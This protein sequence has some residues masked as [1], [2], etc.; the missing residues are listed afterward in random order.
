MAG[1]DA[2]HETCLFGFQSG[3]Y[4]IKSETSLLST[5]TW[6]LLEGD[7]ATCNELIWGVRLSRHKDCRFD[8]D[9]LRTS[10]HRRER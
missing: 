5:I 6:K 7:P 4:E 3:S 2:N 9:Q 8:F 1:K 10:I